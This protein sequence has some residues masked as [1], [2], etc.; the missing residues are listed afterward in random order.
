ML[1]IGLLL[2]F[3]AQIIAGMGFLGWWQVGKLWLTLPV[4]LIISFLVLKKKKMGFEIVRR[5]KFLFLVLGFMFFVNLIGALGPELGFDAL[6]Y[7]LSL[8]K[9]WL[10]SEKI[11]FLNNDFYYS[12]LPKLL[13]MFFAIPIS[14]GWEI[15][16]KL[17]HY[18]FGVLC[19]VATYKLAR[20]YLDEKKSLLAAIVFYANLVVGWMSTTAYIDLGRTF[21]EALA[22]LMF[23]K[24]RYFWCAVV[25]GFAIT[26]KILA[27]GSLLIFLILG[28]PI[29][30]FLISILIPM[31]WLIFSFI[32]TGNPIYPIFSGYDL[33]SARSLFDFVTIFVT[34]ADPILPIYLLI[35]PL[36]ILNFK[37]LTSNFKLKQLFVY[38]FLSLVMWWLTPRTGGGRF[39]LPY[40]PAWSTLTILTI[41]ILKEKNIKYFL[42]III[43]ILV[44]ISIGYRFVANIKYV[45][46]LTGQLTKQEFLDKYL[47]KSFGKNWYYKIS[48][49]SDTKNYIVLLQNN[50][51]LRPSGGFMGSYAKLKFIGWNLVD[52]RI[53][54]IYTPDG[55]LPGHV[56]PP[57]PIQKAFQ[58]GEWRLRDSNWDPDFTVAAPQ[59]AWFFEQGEE[60]K[61]NGIIALN[62]D[63]IR[64]WMD[65]LGSIKTADY[66]E[67]INAQNLY[68]LAQKHA[69]L[70]FF[71]G[72]SQKRD[73]LGSVGRVILKESQRTNVFQKLRFINLIYKNLQEKQIFLWF[74]D[75]KNPFNG[76]L[77]SPLGD[78]FYLVESNLGANKA[79][80]CVTRKIV[81]EINNNDEKITIY[82]KNDSQFENPKPPVF[83]GGNYIGYHRIIIP[84][85]AEVK[86][87]E[88][89]D[90]ETRG[91]LKILGFWLTVPAKKPTSIEINYSFINPKKI[92][93]VKR[94]PGIKSFDYKLIYNGKIIVNKKIFEDSIF[95]IKD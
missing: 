60:E 56:E 49:V 67:T 62:F 26:S 35:V 32:N 84:S 27:F 79:N 20:L 93:Q 40:L 17:I 2:G 89:Y 18:L 54:D 80:C 95:K 47:N 3:Y 78:Y 31:P 41:E 43:V 83:W 4:F 52:M 13:E 50:N 53:M 51:E 86:N 8:P 42:N 44:I 55:Q 37:F 19:V 45:S 81:Q 25:L 92:I 63:F 87:P 82:F 16:A 24:K 9:L 33:S 1:E 15:G 70:D 28:L 94:Q 36:V 7:H 74:K 76:S 69:E 12:A 58:N 23:L 85:E 6:W 91:K 64:D 72:S 57:V 59:I 34:S 5:N 39:L 73:F 61:I 48:E 21:F 11:F 75:K 90:I 30:Y 71:P 66:P 68:E 65:I 77:G 14:I 46:Y 10:I 38:C 88:K 22:L 29:F